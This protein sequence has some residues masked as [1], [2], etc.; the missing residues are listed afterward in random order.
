[1]HGESNLVSILAGGRLVLV[2]W[3][4]RRYLTVGA[5]ADW[6]GVSVYFPACSVVLRI[7]SVGDVTL[8]LGS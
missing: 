6:H 8:S 4:A 7:R 3:H 1:M 5:G 2:W